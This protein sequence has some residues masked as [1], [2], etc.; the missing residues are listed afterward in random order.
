MQGTYSAD[1]RAWWVLA[2]RGNDLAGCAKWTRLAPGTWNIGKDAPVIIDLLR[3]SVLRRWQAGH[4]KTQRVRG[5]NYC[6]GRIPRHGAEPRT[7]GH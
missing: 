7:G 6:T 4:E 2:F 3:A 1:L 5:R